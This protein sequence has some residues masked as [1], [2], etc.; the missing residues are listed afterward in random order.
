MNTPT[1]P[2]GRALGRFGLAVLLAGQLLPMIDFSIINVALDEIARAL[3]ASETE[4]E[5]LVAL[6]GLCF[7]VGLAMGGRLGDSFGRRRVFRCGILVFGIASL[8]CG[9]ADS[10]AQLLLARALQG[11]GAALLVPQV[12]AT[13]HVSLSGAAHSR[14][15]GLYG[16]IGGLAFIVGQVL[17]GFLVSTDVAGL[18]WRSV[19]LVNLPVC[20]AVLILLKRWVP[21]TK[22]DHAVRVDVP[23]TVVLA[24]AIVSL[25]LPLALGPS[26][27]WSWPCVA[28]LLAV[29]PLFGLLGKIELAQ[30]RRGAHPLL[31]P[32][33]LRLSSM[34]FGLL[35]AILFFSCWGGFM[36]V[37]ARALQAGAGLSPIQSGNAFV[38]LGASYFVAAIA[39]SRIVKR[40]GATRT[41]LAGCLVQ[42]PGVLGV[43]ATLHGMWPHPN[44]VSLMPATLFVGAGQALIVSCFYRIS[45]EDV[46]AREAGAGSAM[47]STVMQAAMGLGPALL[48]SVAAHVAQSSGSSFA[49]V[50]AALLLECA[51]MSAL[52]ACI[53]IRLRRKMSPSGE[54][55]QAQVCRQALG[56]TPKARLNCCLSETAEPKPASA[57]ICSID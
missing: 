14:A 32:A 3:G 34:R 30:Q 38:V 55:L 23:G 2:G 35:V 9:L 37:L 6:Y 22:S 1:N 19:F 12:L 25:L 53:V 18:G 42:I 51:I 13:I 11:V 31:P 26:L 33:L 10:I 27:R 15:I 5:L 40:L 44:V 39:S 43:I 54:L 57:A 8:L 16:A 56:E 47:L 21:E 41:L 48:G 28:L 46:P 20:A 52:V 29:L 49:A 17:G 7:A 36:F 4:L 50:S 45:L 24:L